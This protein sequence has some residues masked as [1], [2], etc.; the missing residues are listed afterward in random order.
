[1]LTAPEL[2]DLIERLDHYILNPQGYSDK[3]KKKIEELYELLYK[4]KPISDDEYKVLYFSTEKG[5]I[6]NYSYYIYEKDVEDFNYEECKKWFNEDYPEDLKWYRMVSSRYNNYFAISINSKNVI[7]ADL[8][9]EGNDF[10][11]NQLL[12]LLNFLI[13]KTKNCIEML[14]NGTYND[15]ISKNYSNRNRF[16]VIKRKDYW[17]LYPESKESLLKE[18]SR[19]EI[20]YFV[21]NASDKTD[22]RIKKMTSGKYFECV[23][24]A[25]EANNY[26][27]GNLTDKELYLKYADG[28]DEGLCDLSEEDS[29]QFDKWYNDKSRYGGHPW[30]IMP[31]HSFARVNLC[32]AHDDK[33]YFLFLDGTRVLRNIE[34]AKMYLEFKKHNIPLEIYSVNTIK[35]SLEGT[36]YIGIVPQ[37]IMPIYCESYFKEYN[38]V[39]FIHLKDDKILNH[40]QWEPLEEINL[41]QKQKVRTKKFML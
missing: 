26:E 8:D 16:G 5:S 7:S 20:D 22:D 28:R 31:G 23:K 36:D 11:D 27:I 19:E 37:E 41:K 2:D 13:V 30:E 15:Y 32:V 18:I 34:I 14:E 35:Q 10:I 21:K 29:D 25:Y 1:M 12:E 39:E 24:L 4:I 9:Q 17:R 40:I 6:D 38:P 33:G 3:V